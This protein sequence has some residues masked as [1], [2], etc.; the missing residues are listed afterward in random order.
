MVVVNRASFATRAERLT[1]NGTRTILVK[2]GT[3]DVLGRDVERPTSSLE[4]ATGLFEADGRPSTVLSHE[5]ARM[6]PGLF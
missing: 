1:T 2:F 5:L 3:D 4:V 6:V